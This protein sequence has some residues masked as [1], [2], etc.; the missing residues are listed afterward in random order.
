MRHTATHVLALVLGLT[1][2]RFL[3]GEARQAGRS[4]VFCV[5]MTHDNQRN[6]DEICKIISNTLTPSRYDSAF[7][8]CE[9]PSLEW[10]GK[11]S[12]SL[13]YYCPLD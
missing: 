1:F 7:V 4:T 12:F 5:S 8:Y 9:I 10:D 6:Y 13:A 3:S 11:I 2:P